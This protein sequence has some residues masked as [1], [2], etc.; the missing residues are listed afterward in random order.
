[1]KTKFK[2]KYCKSIEHSIDNC[3]EIIC[4]LCNKKGHAH[5]KCKE[6]INEDYQE[7]EEKEKEK[8]NKEIKIDTNN[9]LIKNKF[10]FNYILDY[11]NEETPWNYYLVE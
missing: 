11:N 3:P 4:R 9:L 2:C 10:Y 6:C 5:W 1:M 7:E 8:E